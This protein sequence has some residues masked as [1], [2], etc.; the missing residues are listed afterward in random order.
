MRAKLSQDRARNCELLAY[1]H[2]VSCLVY[3][4]AMASWPNNVELCFTNGL[5]MFSHMLTA[6]ICV[7]PMGFTWLR[8]NASLR[9]RPRMTVYNAAAAAA[10]PFLHA[11]AP[12]GWAYGPGVCWHSWWEMMMT[13]YGLKPFLTI[14]W[15]FAFFAL[16]W[17]SPITCVS[18]CML[19]AQGVR[20]FVHCSAWSMSF[21]LG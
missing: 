12:K 19:F 5:H 15:L 7:D 8:K 11:G 21:E 17:F 3:S 16:Y 13:D 10:A 1:S 20:F 4:G 2:R 6:N 9:P 18:C 14:L